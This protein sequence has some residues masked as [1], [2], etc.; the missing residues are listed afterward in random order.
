MEI[1]HGEPTLCFMKQRQPAIE[2]DVFGDICL[3]ERKSGGG[4][5]GDAEITLATFCFNR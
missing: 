4:L 5:H 2:D 1:R 3:R